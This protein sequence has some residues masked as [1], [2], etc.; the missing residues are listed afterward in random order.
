MENEKFYIMQET[1]SGFA[2]AISKNNERDVFVCPECEAVIVTRKSK[3]NVYF[4]GNKPGDYYRF[5]KWNIISGGLQDALKRENIT[6][7]KLENLNFQG[8]F[9]KKGNAVSIM[10]DN[11][12][13]I[14]VTGRGGVLC[15]VDGRPVNRCKLCNALDYEDSKTINGISV[16]LGEWDKSDIFY[17]ENWEGNII[18]TQKVK[19]IIENGNFVNVQFINIKDYK[20]E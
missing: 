20:F 5:T 19:D 9:D 17:F 6:G 3:M 11:L 13:E 10:A 12:K 14:V 7:Y 1:N 18:V 15:H 16:N 4:E 8:W 2:K